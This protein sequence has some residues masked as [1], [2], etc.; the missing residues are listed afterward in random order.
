MFNEIMQNDELRNRRFTYLY[1]K[2]I[3]QL[4]DEIPYKHSEETYLSPGERN[5][6]NDQSFSTKDIKIKWQAIGVEEVEGEKC[7]KLLAQ[8]PVFK[9]GLKGARGCVYGIEEINAISQLFA[10][11]KGAMKGKSITIEDV[12]QLLDV[13]VD[14]KKVYRAGN[15]LGEKQYTPES[16]L[17]KKY[18][19]DKIIHTGY[20]YRKNSIIGK[21]KEKKILFLKDGYWLASFGVYV[22]SIYASFGLGNVYDDVV[23]KGSSLFYSCGS[24]NDN[25]LAVRPV[26]YLNSNVTPMSFLKESC[27][28]DKKSLQKLLSQLEEKRQERQR[29]YEEEEK[30][31]IQIKE[32][33]R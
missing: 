21:E 30:I 4:G 32:L 18:T 1:E 29:I 24:W 28:N 7:L 25:K 27:E 17:V 13:V 26:L 8:Q 11:G 12:N 6:Y 22:C 9:L 2:G 33:T 23:D 15:A 20:Y 3:I 10:T 19:K 14:E 31:I 16:F 5:G